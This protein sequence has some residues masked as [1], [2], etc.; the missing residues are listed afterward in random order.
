MV[1]SVADFY[2]FVFSSIFQFL[3]ILVFSIGDFFYSRSGV[4]LVY[5]ILTIFIFF[6]IWVI[7]VILDS[8]YSDYL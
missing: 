1:V 2:E 4:G 7:W 6:V 3:K 8:D 5:I